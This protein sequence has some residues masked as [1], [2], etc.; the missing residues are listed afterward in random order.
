MIPL[1]EFMRPFR[2]KTEAEIKHER[3]VSMA[4]QIMAKLATFQPKKKK[5][6][7]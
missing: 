7:K 4:S 2:R 6:R 3:H 1:P 5:R